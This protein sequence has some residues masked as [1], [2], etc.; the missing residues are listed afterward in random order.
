MCAGNGSHAGCGALALASLADTYEGG[1]ST[2]QQQ[3]VLND[4]GFFLRALSVVYSIADCERL[5]QDSI[6]RVNLRLPL[7]V[8]VLNCTANLNDVSRVIQ[9][10][11]ASV[12]QTYFSVA[13]QAANLATQLNQ[14]PSLATLSSISNSWWP[15]GIGLPQ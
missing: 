8:P 11:K 5:V 4:L 9:D 3:L 15:C 1:H 7:T 10:A 14:G 12:P 2:F 6:D 13:H